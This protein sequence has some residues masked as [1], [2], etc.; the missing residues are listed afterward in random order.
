MGVRLTNDHVP[1]SGTVGGRRPTSVPQPLQEL[2]LNRN[3][4]LPNQ[5]ISRTGVYF[6]TICVECH[7]RLSAFDE[8]LAHFVKAAQS[9]LSI[10]LRQF[11]LISL[12]LQELVWAE[13]KFSPPQ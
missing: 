3:P 13:S 5:V 7:R 4:H 1:P 8:S 10:E 12:G 6:R 2:F 11:E 9:R